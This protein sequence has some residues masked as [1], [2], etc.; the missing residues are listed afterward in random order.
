MICRAWV[1][2]LASTAGLAL[3]AMFI[4]VF[5][6]LAD[7]QSVNIQQAI[8]GEPNQKTKEVSTQQIRRILA[9]GNT[10][11]LDARKHSEY[12]AGHIPG[13]LNAD[14]STGAVVNT[15]MRLVG[16]DKGKALVLYCNGPYCHAS[17]RL[18]EKLI[19][20]G[21]TDVRRYQ[22]G[23]PIWRALGGPTEI[24]LEGIVRIFNI[25][26][27]AVYFDA[28]SPKEFAKGSIPEAHNVPADEL[29]SGVLDKAPLPMDDFNTRIVLFGR[30]ANQ[31]RTLADALSK[32]PWHNVTYYPG[33]FETLRSAIK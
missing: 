17:K 14:V 13:A 27:T 1:H 9:N 5:P 16:G 32:R 19:A 11:V 30:D 22:L 12:V 4:P 24:E 31:A 2:V 8:L 15:V 7:S 26:R 21:F 33:T 20:A 28:R 18:G 6:A 10:I 3:S 25:D 23:M 29:G